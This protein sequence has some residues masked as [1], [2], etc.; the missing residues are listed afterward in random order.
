MNKFLTDLEKLKAA[1][2][3][4]PWSVGRTLLTA[5]TRQWPKDKIKANDKVE[6]LM[7]FSNFTAAD[8]GRSRQYIGQFQTP[9]N[10]AYIAFLRNNADAIADLVRAADDLEKWLTKTVGSDESSQVEIIGTDLGA[11]GTCE[12]LQALRSA[13]A[14]FKG[15]NDG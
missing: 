13:L 4:G 5:Q 9:E 15:G 2:T 6:R 12:R 10:A 11:E 14:A 8:Q 7:L 3:E 1:A